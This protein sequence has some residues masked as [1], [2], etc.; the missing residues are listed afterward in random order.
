MLNPMLAPVV[1]TDNYHGRTSPASKGGLPGLWKEMVMPI[2]PPLRPSSVT[3]GAGHRPDPHIPST[4][5]AH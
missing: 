3:A 1:R 5:D 2:F 4:C